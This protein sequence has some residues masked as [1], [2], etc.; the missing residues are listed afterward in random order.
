MSAKRIIPIT[1]VMRRYQALRKLSQQQRLG[2]AMRLVA[3]PA[4]Q[5]GRT[6]PTTAAASG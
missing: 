6:E 2:E 5:S 1:P 3:N 4:K